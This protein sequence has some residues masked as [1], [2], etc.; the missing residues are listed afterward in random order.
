M[1]AWPRPW[2][3][4]HRLTGVMMTKAIAT[5]SA[6]ELGA[7]DDDGVVDDFHYSD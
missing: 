7:R 5:D 2:Q 4:F 3:I 6:M 1:T